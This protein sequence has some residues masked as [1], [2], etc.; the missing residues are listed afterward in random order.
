M[1]LKASILIVSVYGTSLICAQSTTPSTPQSTPPSTPASSQQPPASTSTSTS[2]SS[3]PDRS[4]TSYVRR[5]SGGITLS[6]LGFSAISGGTTTTTTSTTLSNTYQTSGASSRI[7]YGVTGQVAVT[8]HFAVTVG[9]YYRKIGYQ[10]TNSINTTTNVVEGGVV[11]PIVTTTSTHEDTR[12]HAYDFPVLVRYYGKGRHTPGPRWFVEA[13]GAYRDVNHVRSSEDSTDASS[14]NTCCTFTPVEPQ[15]KT[16][17][18]YVVGTGLQ[19]IDPLGIRVIPEF[20]YTRW[21]QQI[22]D[23]FSTHTQRNQLEASITLSF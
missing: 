6:V 23:S 8:D 7:G 3:A 4:N 9:G 19:L 1:R 5:F 21:Q 18:G 15:H 2:S 11:V 14:V 16:S 22:Y 13:G 12:A 17:V 10:F 20:R